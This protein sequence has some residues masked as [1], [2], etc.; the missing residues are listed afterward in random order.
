MNRRQFVLF[1][2]LSLT[3]AATWAEELQEFKLV[4]KNHRFEPDTLTVPTG[5]KFKLLVENQDPTPEEFESH[6]LNREKVVPGNGKITIFLGPLK[7]GRYVFVGEFNPAT[8]LG[9]IIAK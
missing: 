6:D 1:A 2:A 4:I 5:Q 7:A 9:A 3:L 8:A